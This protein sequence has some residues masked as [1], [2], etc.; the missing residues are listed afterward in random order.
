MLDDWQGAHEVTAAPTAAPA[1]APAAAEDAAEGLQAGRQSPSGVVAGT[2]APAA[3]TSLP[4]EDCTA[5]E[6]WVGLPEGVGQPAVLPGGQEVPVPTPPAAHDQQAEE[7]QTGSQLGSSA[8]PSWPGLPSAADQ[9]QQPPQPLAA[10]AQHAE[11]AAHTE[12]TAANPAATSETAPAIAD[13]SAVAATPVSA[14]A[15]PEPAAPCTKPSAWPSPPALMVPAAGSR[16]VRALRSVPPFLRLALAV[17][18]VLAALVAFLRS[19]WA[20]AFWAFLARS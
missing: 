8:E 12:V 14:A 13:S 16:L 9:L 17:A 6:A 18:V 11:E 1:S 10:D 15:L 7:R 4:Q 2:S 20:G 3:T 5:A 19:P